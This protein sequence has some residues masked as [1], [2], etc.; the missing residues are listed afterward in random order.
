MT[1]ARAEMRN[2]IFRDTGM[3]IE[4]PPSDLPG[5]RTG[6]GDGVIYG[7]LARVAEDIAALDR[8]GLGGIIAVFRM[9]P[10]PHEL[11]TQNLELFMRQVAPQ[12]RD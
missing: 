5:A 9:G 6:R 12:F 8:L 10:M 1:T 2:R 3:R 4:V 7:S 11:A